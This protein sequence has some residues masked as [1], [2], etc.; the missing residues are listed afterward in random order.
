MKNLRD[1]RV[2]QWSETNTRVELHA[3]DIANPASQ[4]W[5]WAGD[6]GDK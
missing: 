2:L 1:D 4:L 3:K 5:R 6:A